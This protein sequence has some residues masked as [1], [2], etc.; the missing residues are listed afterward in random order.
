[1]LDTLYPSISA[2]RPNSHADNPARSTPITVPNIAH[3]V[4]T[5]MPLIRYIVTIVVIIVMITAAQNG[6]KPL[7]ISGI[8]IINI[9]TNVNTRPI[10]D[11]TPFFPPITHISRRNIPTNAATATILSLEYTE[12]FLESP[13]TLICTTTES[14]FLHTAPNRLPSALVAFTISPLYSPDVSCTFNI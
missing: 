10:T 9:A 3:K 2:T 11:L 5:A 8:Y 13:D 12:T 4:F 14:P 1:M 6:E 7:Y